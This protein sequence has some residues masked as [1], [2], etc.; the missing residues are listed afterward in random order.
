MSLDITILNSDGSPD[1]QVS[2]GVDDHYQ[3]M[4]Q[5]E[6]QSLLLLM[7]MRDY[8]QDADYNSDEVLLLSNELKILIEQHKSKS[9][10]VPVATQLLNLAQIAIDRSKGIVAIAD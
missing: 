6:K 2:V 1:E 7:R 4:Q 9:S 5:A 8:Y 3:L 10:F